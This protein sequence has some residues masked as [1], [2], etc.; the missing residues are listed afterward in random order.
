MKRTIRVE[1]RLDSTRRYTAGGTFGVTTN[2]FFIACQLVAAFAIKQL[3]L[4]SHEED[5]KSRE[6]GTPA[7]LT[8]AA[9]GCH[10]NFHLRVVVFE[11]RST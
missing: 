8:C 1:E 4:K 9:C 6:D 3:F 10:Q 2:L 5:N 11:A 7:A